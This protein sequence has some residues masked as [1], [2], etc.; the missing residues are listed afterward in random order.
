MTSE[1]YASDT[2]EHLFN[3]SIIFYS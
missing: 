3:S 1:L 2:K